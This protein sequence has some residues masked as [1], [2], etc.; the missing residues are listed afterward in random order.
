[1]PRRRD[2]EP[3]KDGEGSGFR[4]SAVCS[5]N[6]LVN[7]TRRDSMRRGD[8]ADGARRDLPCPP[9]PRHPRETARDAR[10]A[11]RMAHNP[12]VEG[13][14]PSPATKAR[15]PFSNRERAFCMW[16]CADLGR[17]PARPALLDQHCARPAPWPALCRRHLRART[18]SLPVSSYLYTAPAQRPG[19]GLVSPWRPVPGRVLGNDVPARA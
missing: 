4:G 9:R 7:R 10:D 18:S 17:T 19:W 2:G 14:N 6:R 3:R 16:L 13:S 11:R 8:R 15:G 5:V 1:M 12:E